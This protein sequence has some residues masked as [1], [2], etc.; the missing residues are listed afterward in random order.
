MLKKCHLKYSIYQNNYLWLK[1][2]III[3]K[4]KDDLI[5]ADSSFYF[6]PITSLSAVTCKWLGLKKQ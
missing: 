2:I 5:Q 6:S 3:Q 1:K 4:F